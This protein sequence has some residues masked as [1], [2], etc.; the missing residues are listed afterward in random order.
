[1]TAE[2]RPATASPSDL[3]LA[4]A[5]T[6]EAGAKAYLRNLAPADDPKIA[7]F[8]SIIIPAKHQ[9]IFREALQAGFD[10]FA[11]AR[12]PGAKLHISAAMAPEHPDWGAVATAVRREYFEICHSYQPQ[13]AVSRVRASWIRERRPAEIALM[14]GS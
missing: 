14:R 12:A 11:A 5:F 9:G 7:V 1:M 3:P 10:R 4:L 2:H 13:I 8:A 6:D